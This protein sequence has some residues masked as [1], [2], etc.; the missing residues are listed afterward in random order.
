MTD[1]NDL[2]VTSPDL[3]KARLETLKELFPDLFTNE[4]KLS[5]QS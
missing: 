4:G 2:L 5:Q 1:L 3:S